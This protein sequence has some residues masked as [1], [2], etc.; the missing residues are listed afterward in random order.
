[1]Q[2]EPYRTPPERAPGPRAARRARRGVAL[3]FAVLGGVIAVVV[4]AV[5]LSELAF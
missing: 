4:V 3:E 5:M 1:M 2:E